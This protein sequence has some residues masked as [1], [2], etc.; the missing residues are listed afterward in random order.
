MRSHKIASYPLLLDEQ[1]TTLSCRGLL[2][3]KYF[4][5][6]EEVENAL[7]FEEVLLS[8]FATLSSSP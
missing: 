4:G 8:P 6:D 3:K 2:G 7:R 1:G 5:L